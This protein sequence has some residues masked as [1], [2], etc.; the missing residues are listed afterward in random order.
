MDSAK[1]SVFSPKII[2][3]NLQMARKLLQELD[4][5]TDDLEKTQIY[6]QS[7]P[8]KCLIDGG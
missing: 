8:Y 2:F 3:E 1:T 7:I 5:K 6:R 4:C